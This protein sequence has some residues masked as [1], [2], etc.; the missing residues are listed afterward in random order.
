MSSASKFESS[1]ISY[2]GSDSTLA[3]SFGI[4]ILWLEIRY[5]NRQSWRSA[6]ICRKR[7]AFDMPFNLIVVS[8]FL[9][10]RVKD[11]GDGSR[12]LLERRI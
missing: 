7:S 5:K 2:A 9:K 4:N 6:V 10:T 3:S 12:R 11:Q 8:I 1:L